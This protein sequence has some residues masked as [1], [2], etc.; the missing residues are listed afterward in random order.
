MYKI[1]AAGSL[2]L[3]AL[4]VAAPVAAKQYT[5]MEPLPAAVAERQ[6]LVDAA[7]DAFAD[8]IRIAISVGLVLSVL[9]LI[10]GIVV[11]P[12][13]AAEEHSEVAEADTLAASD[14][15]SGAPG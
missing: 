10:A 15:A 9:V 2:A 4:V 7:D 12:K 14:A 5:V 11:F 1:I 8:G 6:E 3:S 13:G